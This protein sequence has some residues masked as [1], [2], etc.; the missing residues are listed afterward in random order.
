[1][2]QLAVVEQ[3]AGV[4]E[5]LCGGVVDWLLLAETASCREMTGVTGSKGY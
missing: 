2:K 4:P 5:V 3:L 1:M